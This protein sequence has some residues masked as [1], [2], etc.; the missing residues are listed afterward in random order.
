MS[1]APSSSVIVSF[2]PPNEAP[3][4]ICPSSGNFQ[5]EKWSQEKAWKNACAEKLLKN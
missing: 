4:W 2:L 3:L 1:R 5:E